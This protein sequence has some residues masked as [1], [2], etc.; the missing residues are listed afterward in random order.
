MNDIKKIRT[1]EDVLEYYDFKNWKIV[2]GIDFLE[3]LHN[4]GEIVSDPDEPY[5]PITVSE[6]QENILMK[7]AGGK[8]KLIRRKGE[9]R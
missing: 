7:V 4:D 2:S 6:I 1:G 3:G 5:I 9:R 8:W